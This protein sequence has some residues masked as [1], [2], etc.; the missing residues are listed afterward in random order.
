LFPSGKVFVTPSLYRDWLIEQ[1]LYPEWE[2]QHIWFKDDC[3]KY[4]DLLV[5]SGVINREPD[6]IVYRGALIES[7]GEVE[8][9]GKISIKGVPLLFFS[10]KKMVIEITDYLSV[11][12]TF[13]DE[14]TLN[15]IKGIVDELLTPQYFL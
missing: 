14:Q 9:L 13:K 12:I 6:F 5:Q 4:Q 2:S 11:K 7:F 8:I 1:Y 15:Q 3:Q 10:D